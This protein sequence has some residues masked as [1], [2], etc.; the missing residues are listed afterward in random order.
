MTSDAG[1]V[2]FREHGIDQ[3]CE[4]QHFIAQAAHETG[5]FTILWESGAYSAQQILNI[6]GV[7]KHSAKVSVR[8]ANDIAA[9]PVGERT[10]VLFERVYG[11]GN[12]AKA[13]ELGNVDEGDGWKYRGFGI[14]QTT[15]RRDHEKYLAGETTPIAALRAALKEWDA[16]GCNELAAA[17]DIKR[18]TKKI[19]GGY[20]GLDDRRDYLVKAKR[21]IRSL[22][23]EY[24]PPSSMATS[25]T[26]NTAIA[27]G[28]GGGV[29]TATEVSTAMAKVAA[30]GRFS[31]T[32]FLMALASSPT[33]W[34]GLFTVAG[35]VYVW[36]E[37]RRKL[38]LKG[39]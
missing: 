17:D 2:L 21:F 6:F 18:I 20:N 10:E 30:T 28:T 3:A 33:F 31:A 36:L 12:P 15:G 1:A 39:V 35:A 24:V 8:E 5:G 37:R 27:L 9:L 7:G 13:R 26:G 34:I 23:A 29:T 11:L 22:P 4:L 38:I 32:A 25:T 14:L 19:N 16:K